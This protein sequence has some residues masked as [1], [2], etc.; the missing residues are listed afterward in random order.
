MLD[1]LKMY[2]KNLALILN[3]AR[4]LLHAAQFLVPQTNSMNAEQK[5]KMKKTR[6]LN[7]LTVCL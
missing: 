3:L 6:W 5:R 4:C 1:Q 2:A 7:T